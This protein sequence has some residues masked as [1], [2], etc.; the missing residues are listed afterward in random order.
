MKIEF[1]IKGVIVTPYQKSVIEKK[2]MKLK[3]YLKDEPMIIDVYLTDE[4]SIEKGGVDQSV[5]LSAVF[6][7]EKIF[8]KEID[9]QLMRAFAFAYRSFERNIQRFHRKRID[10]TRKSSTTAIDRLLRRL[11]IRE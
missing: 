2:L 11:R 7:N 3:R 5:E 4:S 8:T 1:H 9:D 6:D 10:R